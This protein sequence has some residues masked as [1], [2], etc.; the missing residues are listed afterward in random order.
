M[1]PYYY[2]G[3]IIVIDFSDYIDIRLLNG[4]EALIYYGE[5]RYLKRVFFEEG[6]GNLI[7]KSYNAAYSD[8]VIKNKDLDRVV[9]SG[10]ISMVI[11]I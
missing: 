10:V 1:K 5:E 11:N 2:D 6:T 8:I 3:D 4:E 7:L 9:C